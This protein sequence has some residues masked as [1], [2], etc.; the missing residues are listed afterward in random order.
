[1]TERQIEIM[2]ELIKRAAASSCC[3]CC[4]ECLACDATKLLRELEIKE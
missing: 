3:V 4:N 2:L 1:M